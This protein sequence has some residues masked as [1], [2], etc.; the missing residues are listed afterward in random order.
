MFPPSKRKKVLEKWEPF[1]FFSFV[2]SESSWEWD[3]KISRCKMCNDALLLA[4]GLVIYCILNY[5]VLLHCEQLASCTMGKPLQLPQYP[6]VIW[7]FLMFL[8]VRWH[9]S[10]DRLWD[11][12][13][14]ATFRCVHFHKSALST[15]G[16]TWPLHIKAMYGFVSQVTIS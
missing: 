7:F 9:E 6:D 8:K 3:W 5:L 1:L 12:Q 2:W 14:V 13:H 15:C 10:D 4:A 11:F 16:A